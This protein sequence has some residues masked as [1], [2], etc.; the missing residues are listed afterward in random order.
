MSSCRRYPALHSTERPRR[1]SPRGEG[2]EVMR[3]EKVAAVHGGELAQLRGDGVERLAVELDA[4]VDLRLGDAER[5]REGIDLDEG[6]GAGEDA[7]LDR[8]LGDDA[9]GVRF[10]IEEALRLLVGD[11]LD[12]QHQPLAMDAADMRMVA[13]ALAQLAP[14][15]GAERGR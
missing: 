14:E 4:L 6:Q 11:E 9:M 5:R 10:R 3:S 7:V 13:H 12:R 1:P 15:I 8:L 2:R